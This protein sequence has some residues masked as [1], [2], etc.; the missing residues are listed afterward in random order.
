MARKN[1]ESRNESTQFAKFSE[2]IDDFVNESS[3]KI[4]DAGSTAKDSVKKAMDA[5]MAQLD[6][7]GDGKVGIEDIIVLAI[8]SPSST[9]VMNS[10]CGQRLMIS[11]SSKLSA[12]SPF[13]RFSGCKYPI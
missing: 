4:I 11:P 7:N 12:F 13:S 8:K 6:A 9:E 10:T 2:R 5:V 3:G 1:K